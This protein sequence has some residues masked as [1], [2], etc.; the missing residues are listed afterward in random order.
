MPQS[1]IEEIRARIIEL[2]TRGD[3]GQEFIGAVTRKDVLATVTRGEQNTTVSNNGLDTVN[4]YSAEAIVLVRAPEMYVTLVETRHV[5]VATEWQFELYSPTVY[6]VMA[7]IRWL[8]PSGAVPTPA[9]DESTVTRAD[10][11]AA[12]DRVLAAL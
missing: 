12:L 1:T 6:A 5:G 8:S 4:Q 3:D 9:G 7:E 10:V 11:L 2:P